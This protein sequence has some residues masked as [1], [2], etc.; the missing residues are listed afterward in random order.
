V[1][2]SMDAQLASINEQLSS[3]DNYAAYK[4]LEHFR[5]VYDGYP[6]HSAVDKKYKEVSQTEEVKA[7][8]LAAKKVA[9]AVRAGSKNTPAA[10]KRAVGQLEKVIADF[11]NT[12]AA[13]EAQSLLDQ[14]AASGA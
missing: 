3:G 4:A 14:V 11:P 5:N 10:V 9:A 8:K 13:V 12:E 7:E 1:K 2:T 6:M